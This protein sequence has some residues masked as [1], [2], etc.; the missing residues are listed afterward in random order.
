MPWLWVFS[1]LVGLV[2]QALVIH[3]LFRGPWREFL[4]V[5]VYCIGMFFGTVVSGASFFP[6]KE[7]S[8]SPL[9]YAGYYWITDGILQFLVLG[10]VLSLVRSAAQEAQAGAM[11]ARILGASAVMIAL[12]SFVIYA[13]KGLNTRM[14]LV[15]RNVGFLAVVANLVLWAFLIRRRH[16]DRTLLLLSG[17]LGV[18]M[19]GKAIGH[20][21]RTL[22]PALVEFGNLIIVLSYLFG[23][24]VWWQAFRHWRPNP[25]PLGGV[26]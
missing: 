4:T 14:T 5:F 7:I 22:A 20:S 10:V 12:L 25:A 21:L 2:L 23:L 26:E 13:D 9:Y 19:A 15:A 24:Y 17:G 3:S 18:E 8:R 11:F 1:F 6:V 16:P